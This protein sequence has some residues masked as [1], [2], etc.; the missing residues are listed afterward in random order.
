[1]QLERTSGGRTVVP[2]SARAAP[3]ASTAGLASSRVA[4]YIVT[5]ESA[6][7]ITLVDGN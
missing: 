5:L 1:M 7:E 4:G 6:A 3:I 2:G